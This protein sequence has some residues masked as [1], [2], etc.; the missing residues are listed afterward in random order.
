VCGVYTYIFDIEKID[1]SRD[2][3]SLSAY[4]L[5]SNLIQG[6][7]NAFQKEEICGYRTFQKRQLL[8]SWKATSISLLIH[9]EIALACL[10]GLTVGFCFCF[11][12]FWKFAVKLVD[13]SLINA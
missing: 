6:I 2:A 3:F 7:E 9:P 13:L 5:T 1:L 12:L 11:V 4:F 8:K 10:L